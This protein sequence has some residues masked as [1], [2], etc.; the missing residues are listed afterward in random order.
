MGFKEHEKF[1]AFMALGFALLLLAVASIIY[2]PSNDGV[3]RVL[4]ACVG[5]FSLALGAATNALFRIREEADKEVK[6]VNT[7][8]EPAIVAETHLTAAPAP[9]PATDG[10]LPEEEKLR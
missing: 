7:P 8:S 2:P 3:Q 10:E 9:A 1:W 6:V 5:A 4:D